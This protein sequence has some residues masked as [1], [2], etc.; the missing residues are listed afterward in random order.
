MENFFVRIIAVFTSLILSGNSIEIMPFEDFDSNGAAIG[1]EVIVLSEDAEDYYDT[2]SAID[3]SDVVI[4]TEENSYD[5][6]NQETT[7]NSSIVVT[8][9]T[10][11]NSV[12]ILDGQGTCRVSYLALDSDVRNM[13]NDRGKY[14]LGDTATI[15][16]T[17]PK[18]PGYVFWGWSPTGDYD[19]V[20]TSGWTFE[21][22]GDMVFYATW[23]EDDSYDGSLN[24]SNSNAKSSNKVV[25]AINS[26]A[27]SLNGTFPL[28]YYYKG[29]LKSIQC[30]SFTDHIWR[31]VFGISRY[32]ANKKFTIVNSK[33]KLKGS[34][35]YDFLKANNASVGDIIWV[36][37]PSYASD[38]YNITHFML[39]MGYDKDSLI[40]SDGYERNGKGVIWKN[41]QRVSFNGDHAKYFSGQCYVRLYHINSSVKLK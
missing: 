3:N 28:K 30:C 15:P 22:T 5:Y 40:I 2:G 39:L 21:I 7:D 10:E 14:N 17:E 19:C 36:H 13:P 11:D 41:D 35:I 6:S 37:D 31:N 18:R 34:E 9:S 29:K 16:A 33:K 4:I 1:D 8:G 38:K 23:V 20:Y 24:G 12:E 25:N 26:Y 27:N 32:D